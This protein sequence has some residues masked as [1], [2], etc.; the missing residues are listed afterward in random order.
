MRSMTG[1]GRSEMNVEGME[2]SVEIKSV[3]H[4]FADYNIRVPR[5]YGFMEEA[6]KKHLQQYISR[7]KVDVYVSISDKNDDSKVI[8]LNSAL[9]EGYINAMRELVEKYGVKDDISAASLSRFSDIFDVEY[10][11]EDE[12]TIFGR[13]VPVLEAATEQFISMRKREGEKLTEDMLMRKGIIEEKLAKVEQLAPNT[14]D[15]YKEKLEARIAELMDGITIDES[16]VMTEIAIFADK[17]CVTEETVRLHSHL[18]EFEHILSQD[19][20]AGRRLDFLLQEMNREVNTMGSKCNDLEIGR[21]V[22][23][24]KTELEKIREQLQ[25]LE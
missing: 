11:E 20:A 5:Y 22:V 16:R 24:M 9:A 17:L 3:N 13:V 1:Y 12:E 4:R 15:D 6:V 10:K 18:K 7:G 19:E 25:N 14:V 8:T 21:C 2:I 23:D